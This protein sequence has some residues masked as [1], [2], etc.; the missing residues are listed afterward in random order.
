MTNSSRSEEVP[1]ANRGICTSSRLKLL[2]STLDSIDEAVLVVDRNGRTLFLNDAARGFVGP[3]FETLQPSEWTTALGCCRDD[4]VTPYSTEELPLVRAMRGEHVRDEDM[5]LRRQGE[6]DGRWLRVNCAPLVG[7]DGRVEG[8]ILSFRDIT[9]RKR[10][11]E[12]MQKFHLAVQRSTDCVFITDS[13]GRI[14]YVNPAFEATTGYSARE[15][16]GQEP[17][18][19]KSGLHGRNLYEKLWSTIL[20]GNVYSGTIINRKKNGE[21]FHAEQTI[22]PIQNSGR[23]PSHFVTVV[24]DITELKRAQAREIEMRLAQ[25]IQQSLY[26]RGAPAIEGFDIGGAAY[27]ADATGGDYFDFIP[28]AD[29]RICIAIGDVSGHGFGTALLMAEARAYLRSLVN[30][31]FDSGEIL[32][33]I[34]AFLCADSGAE[35]FITLMVLMLDGRKRRYTYA[36]A[37][38]LPGYLLD[39]EGEVKSIFD[40]TGMPLGLFPEYEVETRGGPPL[41]PGDMMFFMTDGVNETQNM[42]EEFFDRSRAL[43]VVKRCRLLPAAE[44]AESIYAAVREFAANGPQTDDITAVICKCLPGEQA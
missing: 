14:E 5:F 9:V 20:S 6:A 17:R 42:A 28:L 27:P 41:T 4:E 36:S 2:E 38:H 12:V 39:A 19:L 15:A 13:T 7:S 3:D 43:E 22:T 8:G 31:T 29:G 25:K 32:R 40:S 23:R 34:N 26:P 16:I 24:R 37:G 18:I 1:D 21:L 30:T 10:Q 35:R 33:R 44:I 11:G